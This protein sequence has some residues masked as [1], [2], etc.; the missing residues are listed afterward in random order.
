MQF[1]LEQLKAFVAVFEKGSFS[2]A[3]AK[4]KK[5]RTTIGQVITNLEDQLAVDLFERIGRSAEPTAEAKLLYRYAKQTIEQASSFDKMALSLSFGQLEEITIA[6]CHFIP[7]EPLVRI[8]LKLA[9]HFPSMKVHFRVMTKEQI[10]QAILNDEVQIGIVNIDTRSAMTSFDATFLTNVSHSIFTAA[11]HPL[12]QATQT[13]RLSQLKINKQILL[14]AYIDDGMADKMI[15]SPDY[16][17]VSD[18]QLLLNLVSQGVGWAMFPIITA[19]QFSAELAINELSLNEL[20]D[21]FFVPVAL[22]FPHSKPVLEVKKYVADVLLSFIDE[23]RIHRPGT[24]N[25]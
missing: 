8:R 13:D 16:E 25:R 24:I 4:L 22:W 21:D 2:D 5:H 23:Y 12:Q 19:K 15:L 3:A 18:M 7:A 14:A 11:N 6:Y 20:N 17:I 1:S 9:E 10:R